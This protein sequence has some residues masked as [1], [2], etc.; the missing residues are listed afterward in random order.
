VEV[1][2]TELRRQ[3]LRARDGERNHFE[4]MVEGFVDNVRVL[5]RHLSLI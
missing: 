5:T 4:K 2:G 3:G 1:N